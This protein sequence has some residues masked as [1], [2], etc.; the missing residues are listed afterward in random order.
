[1]KAILLLIVLA[2]TG[3]W[4]FVGSRTISEGQVTG[5]YQ[6]QQAATLERKPDVLCALLADDFSS[7]GSVALAGHSRSESVT[8]PQLCES[9]VDMYAAWDKLGAAMGGEVQLDS[10]YD[11]HS[12]GIAPDR[13]SATVDIS[14]S[15]DV[16]GNL[17]NLRSRSTET[18][19]RRNGKVLL[20]RSEGSASVGPGE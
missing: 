19:V 18:L 13:K 5:F 12:I 10:H 20:L 7:S 2:G 15:L 16:A 4:Y 17:T 3:W 9:Y 14:M 8:K 6:A 1:M 11:I